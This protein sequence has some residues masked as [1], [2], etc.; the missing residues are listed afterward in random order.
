MTNRKREKT[1]TGQF[2]KYCL[3]NGQFWNGKFRKRKFLTSEIWKMDN[4]R[5]KKSE[6][7]Q[8]WKGRI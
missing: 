4:Y 7:G 5:Q 6:K 8:F 2:R 3:A 1:E